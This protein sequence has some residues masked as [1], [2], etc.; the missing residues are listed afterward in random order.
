MQVFLHSW[1]AGQ[2]RRGC[3][4]QMRM[5][6]WV[7]TETSDHTKGQDRHTI[8][9]TVLIPKY[10]WRNGESGPHL[11]AY[12]ENLVLGDTIMNTVVIIELKRYEW[13][14]FWSRIHSWGRRK[15]AYLLQKPFQL[16]SIHFSKVFVLFHNCFD[17]TII[18]SSVTMTVS[19]TDKVD[20]WLY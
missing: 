6:P 4:V 2:K 7:Y 16:S 12:Q 1:F 15:P 10:E 13:R 20:L 11:P 8:W 9:Q 3:R 14:L 18:Q 19:K 5:W 17:L